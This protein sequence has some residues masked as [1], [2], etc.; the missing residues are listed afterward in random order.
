MRIRFFSKINMDNMKMLPPLHKK[1]TQTTVLAK[2]DTDNM[3]MLSA[4]HKN[5][6]RTTFLIEKQCRQVLT[7]IHLYFNNCFWVFENLSA[8]SWN[9]EICTKQL[10]LTFASFLHFVAKTGKNKQKLLSTNCNISTFG[11]WI[12]KNSKVE[13]ELILSPRWVNFLNTLLFLQRERCKI[14]S[15]V[16]ITG[17]CI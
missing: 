2:N 7:L 9:I 11:W 1:K 13:W 4:L 8:Q 5:K 3:K 14:H 6:M 12:F 10:L 17:V 15:R 16:M